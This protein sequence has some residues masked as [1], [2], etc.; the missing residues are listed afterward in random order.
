MHERKPVEIFPRTNTLYYFLFKKKL[1]KEKKTVSFFESYITN[2]SPIFLSQDQ[3]NS[4]N[5]T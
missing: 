4:T 1:N 2:Q 5:K 3:L